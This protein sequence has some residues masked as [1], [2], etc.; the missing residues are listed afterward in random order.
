MCKETFSL[1]DFSYLSF[2]SFIDAM[3]RCAHPCWQTAECI[4]SYLQ[5]HCHDSRRAILSEKNT[6]GWFKRGLFFFCTLI[7]NSFIAV[8]TIRCRIA[9]WEGDSRSGYTPQN[10]MLLY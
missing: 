8:L 2:L 9:L 4:S 3:S 6:Q 7:I 10:Y 5:S 1:Y